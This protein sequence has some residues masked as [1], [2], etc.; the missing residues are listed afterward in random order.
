MRSIDQDT[1]TD[2]FGGSPQLP[3]KRWALSSSSSCLSRQT[4]PFTTA[5]AWGWDFGPLGDGT[6]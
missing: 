1:I 2:P 5:I 6:P 4:M 3:V